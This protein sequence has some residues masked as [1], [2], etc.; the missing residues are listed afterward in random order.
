[1]KLTSKAVVE[2]DISKASLGVEG[3]LAVRLYGSSTIESV[4]FSCNLGNTLIQILVT[5]LFSVVFNSTTYG[6]LGISGA[7]L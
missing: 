3:V 6:T 4:L 7:S 1:M 5:L 2:S